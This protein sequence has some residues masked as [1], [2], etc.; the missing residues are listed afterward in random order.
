MAY[1]WTAVVHSLAPLPL[2]PDMT[3][4]DLALALS[5]T[6]ATPWLCGLGSLSALLATAASPEE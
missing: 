1:V 5:P 4:Q 3:M 2:A 6:L